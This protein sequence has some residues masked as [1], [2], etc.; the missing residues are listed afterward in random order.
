MNKKV[1]IVAVPDEVEIQGEILNY[2]IIN[3]IKP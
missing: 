1:F 2:P 3:I